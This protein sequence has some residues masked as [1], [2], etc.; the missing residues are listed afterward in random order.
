MQ[1]CR[2]HTT[3]AAGAG[4]TTLGRALAS[5]LGSPHYDTDDYY[6]RPSE[7]PYTEKRPIA[8]RLHLMEEHFLGKSKWV[9]SG[10]LDSWGQSVTA[11]FDSV[12]FVTAPTD[13]RLTRLRQREAQRYGEEAVSPGGWRHQATEQFIEWASH[14]DDGTQPGRNLTRHQTWLKSL[15]CRVIRVDGTKAIDTLAAETARAIT[16]TG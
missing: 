4:V 6:W 5:I 14:Y 3:G 15:S 12:V 9:L 10:S 13:I 8:E 7:D 16:S 2:V 11:M 1:N